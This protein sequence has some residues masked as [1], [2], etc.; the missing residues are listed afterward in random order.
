VRLTASKLAYAWEFV[1]EQPAAGTTEQHEQV[2]MTAAQKA[3]ERKSVVTVGSGYVQM[4]LSA[5]EKASKGKK[6]RRG[7][8]CASEEAATA[9]QQRAKD[10]TSE[11][12]C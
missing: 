2:A 1:R 7:G 8:V 12:V 4:L 9:G 11:R 3:A 6:G 5:L 10:P